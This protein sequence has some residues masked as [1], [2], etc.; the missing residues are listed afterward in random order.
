MDR[1]TQAREALE[2]ANTHR[3][4]VAYAKRDIAALDVT[5]GREAVA[6]LFA[7]CQD[8]GVLAGR[9]QDYLRAPKRTG[10][11]K[12]TRVMRDMGI[13]R[14]DCRVRDLTMRQRQLI[15]HAVLNG[16]RVDLFAEAA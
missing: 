10:S 13:K 11:E 15:A 2:K 5:A 1:V 4:A 3:L 6:D 16:Y 7:T 12:S 9:V 14:A 8:P